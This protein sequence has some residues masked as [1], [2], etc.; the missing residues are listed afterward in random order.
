[1]RV[2]DNTSTLQAETVALMGI[3]AHASQRVRH[4]VI[5]IDPRVAIYRLQYSMPNGIDLLTIA[6]TIAQRI[7]AQGRRIYHKLGSLPQ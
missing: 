4:V 2:T 6:I 7:I 5:L 1:M 3:L